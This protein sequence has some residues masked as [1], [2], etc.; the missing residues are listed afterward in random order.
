MGQTEVSSGLPSVFGTW[1]MWERVGRRAIELAL[2]GRLLG[3]VEAQ[4]LGFVQEIVPREEV[5]AAG[6]AAAR[7]LA[8]Q[9]AVAY[10]LSKV[11]NRALDQARYANAMQMAL[12]H[13]REAFDSGAPQAEIGRFFERRAQRRSTVPAS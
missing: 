11:A 5:L 3:A 9:P 10:R 8:A 7:R 13:Y 1:L 2:Q 6:L 12:S 4:Q